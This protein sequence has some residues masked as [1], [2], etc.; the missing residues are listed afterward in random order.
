LTATP[1]VRDAMLAA[2]PSLRA[3]AIS[4]TYNVDAADDLV[5]EAILRAWTNIER[6]EPGTS[7][8]AWLFTILRN[9]FYSQYRK[10]HREVE[11]PSGAYADRLVTIPEQDSRCDFEDLR[12]ALVKLPVDQREALILIAAEGLSYEETAEVCG[13]AVGTVKSRV[14]RARERL[15]QLLAIHGAEDLGPDGV[16]QAALQS[17]F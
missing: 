3:F 4:L 12:T 13:V 10:A 14:H 17:A 2:I 16:T 15:G 8:N 9:A 1:E 7:M 11:D 5:Q 6:F